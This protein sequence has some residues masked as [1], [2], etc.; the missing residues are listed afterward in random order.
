MNSP[1]PRTARVLD[2]DDDDGIP[3]WSLVMVFIGGGLFFVALI[4]YILRMC[5]CTA[6]RPQHNTD[7]SSSSVYYP[8]NPYDPND[9][10]NPYYHPHNRRVDNDV[11]FNTLYNPVDPAYSHQVLF[12]N[13]AGEQVPVTAGQPIRNVAR[14]RFH[15]DGTE[16]DT[17]RAFPQAQA[18]EVDGLQAVEPRHVLNLEGHLKPERDDP[19][20]E[21]TSLASEDEYG[22][23]E[24]IVQPVVEEQEVSLSD[25]VR[26]SSPY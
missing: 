18:V 16:R 9:E 2:D 3:I 13:E 20:H 5:V 22:H 23:A 14:R 17:H 24:Y 6:K 15:Q 21:P 25:T 19:R 10:N 12:V 26:S 8:T 7:D 1:L 11:N 4:V